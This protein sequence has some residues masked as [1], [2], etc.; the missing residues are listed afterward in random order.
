LEQPDQLHAQLTAQIRISLGRGRE[1]IDILDETV[2]SLGEEL[3]PRL[4]GGKEMEP[5]LSHRMPALEGRRPALN[6]GLSPCT[7][8]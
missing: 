3:G 1:T 8:F 4:I 6:L 2:E 7:G 5:G